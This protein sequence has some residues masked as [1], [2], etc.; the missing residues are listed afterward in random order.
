VPTVRDFDP[1]SWNLAAGSYILAAN[2]PYYI[3]GE[4]LRKFLET[5]AQ[6]RTIAFLVQK[7]SHKNNWRKGPPEADSPLAE[8]SPFFLFP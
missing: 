2:I 1:G 7:K 8:K 5:P 4:L 3:T 6:P